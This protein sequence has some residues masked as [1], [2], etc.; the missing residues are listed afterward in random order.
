MDRAMKRSW[1]RW[2]KGGNI[3]GNSGDWGKARNDMENEG[4]PG[5]SFHAFLL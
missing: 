1:K 5:I 4:D 3:G 2:R